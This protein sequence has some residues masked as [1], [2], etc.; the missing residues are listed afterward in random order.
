MRFVRSVNAPLRAMTLAALFGVVVGLNVPAGGADFAPD[1]NFTDSVCP[2]LTSECRGITFIGTLAG[3]D[4]TGQ[5]ESTSRNSCPTC[6]YQLNR[7]CTNSDANFGHIT[8]P[9]ACISPTNTPCT[10]TVYACR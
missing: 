7:Q 5:C 4:A 2:Q 10:F 9:G 3:C 6:T 1:Q 8:C